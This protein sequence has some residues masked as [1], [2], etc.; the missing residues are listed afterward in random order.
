MARSIDLLLDGARVRELMTA[1]EER[2]ALIVP[3][4]GDARPRALHAGLGPPIRLYLTCSDAQSGIR[5]I[6]PP[7]GPA[8]VD[9]IL[10]PV[11]DL[12]IFAPNAD[13]L[14]RGW[15]QYSRGRYIAGTWH[16]FP[17]PY[18]S[19]AEGTVRWLR[20]NFVRDPETGVYM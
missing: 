19:W 8:Y 7:D 14:S 6:S 4:D 15:L 12:A 9:R 2:K 1:L 20:R 16:D 10:S 17:R 11:I 5:Y 13:G 18:L 3:H